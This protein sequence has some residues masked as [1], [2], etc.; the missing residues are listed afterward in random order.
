MQVDSRSWPGF[1]LL[2]AL[3]MMTGCGQKGQLYRNQA[4]ETA[5]V[6]AETG[7]QTQPTSRKKGQAD[8]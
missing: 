5:S 7:Q 4:P 6:S 2:L 1:A 8:H 3:L